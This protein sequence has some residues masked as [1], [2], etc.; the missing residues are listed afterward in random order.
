V[1][2]FFTSR[3]RVANRFD[4]P[5]ADCVQ[6]VIAGDQNP[7]VARLLSPEFQSLGH[8]TGGSQVAR[9][10]ITWISPTGTA[11]FIALAW[12]A[13]V[14]VFLLIYIPV[15]IVFFIWGHPVADDIFPEVFF[16]A[17]L[18]PIAYYVIGWIM[19][20]LAAKMFNLFSRFTK[21][22]EI[23]VVECAENA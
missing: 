4:P 8:Q 9:K 18:L 23:E 17:V 12:A 5:K 7:R 22:V 15:M 21:G 14:L 3:N 13:I 10:R 6:P 20:Y 11:H 16:I 2:P 19:G 1:L